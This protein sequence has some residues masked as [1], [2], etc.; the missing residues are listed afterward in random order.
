MDNLNY[1]SGG[2]HG[3][4]KRWKRLGERTEALGQ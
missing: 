2:G 4:E 3:K 1:C